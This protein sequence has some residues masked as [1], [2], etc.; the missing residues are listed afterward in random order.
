MRPLIGSH[1]GGVRCDQNG[2][3]GASQVDHMLVLGALAES[4]FTAKGLCMKSGDSHTPGTHV[5]GEPPARA[6]L[7]NGLPRGSASEYPAHM[8]FLRTHLALKCVALGVMLIVVGALL[9]PGG[10]LYGSVPFQVAG[11]V[12]ALVVYV[13]LRLRR[14][15]RSY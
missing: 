7:G 1:W 3:D 2:V 5:T 8:E 14:N 10:D 9:S 6:G 12:L 4:A 15:Q 13:L 11:V